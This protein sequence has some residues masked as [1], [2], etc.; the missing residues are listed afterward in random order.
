MGCVRRGRD[1][2]I[3][4]QP[5]THKRKVCTQYTM[6]DTATGG[7]TARPRRRGHPATNDPQPPRP[8]SRCLGGFW[9]LGS[10]GSRWALLLD[11][12]AEDGGEADAILGGDLAAWLSVIEGFDDFDGLLRSERP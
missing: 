10:R 12:Y 4:L 8:L 11:G 2:V 1:E 3:R 6:D 7:A 9:A 5:S